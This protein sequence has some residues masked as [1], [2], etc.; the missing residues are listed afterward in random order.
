MDVNLGLGILQSAAPR[1]YLK[2]LGVG[3]PVFGES[4]LLT[5]TFQGRIG[6]SAEIAGRGFGLTKMHADAASGLLPNLHVMTASVAGRV[7]TLEFNQ[8]AVR[9]EGTMY[10]WSSRE[11]G[12]K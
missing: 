6:A 3:L 10:R 12:N 7:A 1:R 8:T 11:E 4:R 2:V 5:E 9:F